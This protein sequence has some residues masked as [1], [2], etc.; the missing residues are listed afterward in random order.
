M[1][2]MIYLCACAKN[3]TNFSFFIRCISSCLKFERSQ[4]HSAF[5]KPPSPVELGDNNDV[6][7]T[8]LELSRVENGYFIRDDTFFECS[9]CLKTHLCDIKAS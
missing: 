4:P 7:N 3:A 9:L 2:D 1:S 8:S 5:S 6:Q